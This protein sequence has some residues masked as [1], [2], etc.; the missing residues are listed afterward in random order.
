MFV[1]KKIPRLKKNIKAHEYLFIYNPLYLI[2]EMRFV[3]VL[4]LPV[5]FTIYKPFVMFEASS[6]HIPYPLTFLEKMHWPD[7]LYTESVLQR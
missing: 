7:T 6:S 4:F 2:R 5:N 1:E 3:N